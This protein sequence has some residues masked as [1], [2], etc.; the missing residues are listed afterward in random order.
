MCTVSV[1]VPV[2]NA[3]RTLRRCVESLVLGEEKSLEVILVEDRSGDGSW[4][5][6]E[7]L[8]AEYPNVSC[9]RNERNSGVSHTRNVG[10][11]RASGEYVLFAD[12]DDWASCR[13]VSELL[14][15]AQKYPDAMAVCGHH[16]IDKVNASQRDY[17][18]SDTPGEYIVGAEAL[19]VLCDRF[20]LQQLWNKI[21]RRDVIEA[22]HVRFDETQSMGEDFQFVLDYLEAGQIGKLAVLNKPLY[23]YIR[24]NNNSLMGSFGFSQN[25]QEFVRLEQLARLAGPESVG[26]RDAMIAG[27]KQNY[28]YHI[29]RNRKHSKE[30]K[31]EAIR[32]VMSDGKEQ[33][34]YRQQRLLMAKEA[35]AAMPGKGK[36]LYTRIR[37][38]VSRERL[39]KKLRKIRAAVSAKN[40]TIISQNC[41]GGV[42]YHDMGMQ[43]RSPTINLFIKEPDFVRFVLNL[44]HYMEQ[45]LVMRWGETYPIGNLGDIEIHFMHY[46]T[47]EEARES[48]NR[49]RE[50]INWEKILVLCT[51]RDGFDGDTY[52]QWK[53]I[54]Y[55]KVLFTANLDYTEDAVYYPE[56]TADGC[57]GDLIPE[58]EFYQQGA[59]LKA[60]DSSNWINL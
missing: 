37:G 1:I 22:H 60:L 11:D 44:R 25:R 54:P 7:A 16:F 9:V 17:L 32:N 3:E 26:R 23:Y 52:A 18:W 6:C 34:Y 31:L 15:M 59:L 55:P 46:D 12:S 47:C 13:Y 43:F 53:Q 24:W 45:E 40:F 36:A 29:V 28:V 14:R 5:L 30:E 27:S 2:Y 38:R 4:A 19:F 49:R 57:V 48:W 50:R 8:A 56:Y 20:L 33:Q 51:D 42:F 21:F 41:I 35:L 39:E 10:L 58:R